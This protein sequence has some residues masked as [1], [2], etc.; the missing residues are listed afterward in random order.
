[1][2]NPICH[3]QALVGTHPIFH[4]SRIR[5]KLPQNVSGLKHNL[6]GVY[7]LFLQRG[8]QKDAIVYQNFIIPYF[9]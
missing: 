4:V 2:L 6:Q 9:K 7:N 1:M 5:V 8:T 3:L